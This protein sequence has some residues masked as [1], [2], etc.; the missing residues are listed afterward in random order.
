MFPGGS[1][2]GGERRVQ[3]ATAADG[4]AEAV[5]PEEPGAV[6]ADE[7]EQRVLA[8]LVLR[9]RPRRSPAEMTQSARTPASSAASAASSTAPPGRRSTAR[10]TGSGIVGDRAVAAH[11]GDG[12]AVAVDRIRGAGE[13]AGEDVAEELAA[14]RAAPARRADDGDRLRLEERAQRRDDGDVVARLDARA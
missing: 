1:A 3:P 10:S 2:R 12:L 5:R 6:G 9:R 11:A 7:A 8:L 13:L 4:D 14:D